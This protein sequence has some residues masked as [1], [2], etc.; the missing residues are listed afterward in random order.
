MVPTGRFEATVQLFVMIF[1]H[2]TYQAMI[3]KP[4]SHTLLKIK[5]VTIPDGCF[6]LAPEK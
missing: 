3:W 4:G 1:A 6:L 2:C 5:R